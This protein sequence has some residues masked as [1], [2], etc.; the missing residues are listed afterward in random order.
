MR[1][2]LTNDDGVKAPSLWAIHDALQELGE[3]TVVA[4]CSEQ[5][6]VGHAITYRTPITAERVRSESG[7][8]A[9]AV[10]GT[11]AD[12]VK[13]ALLE[14]LSEPPDLVV[15][16]INLGMNLGCNVFYSG[17]VAAAIEGAMYGLPSVAVSTCPSNSERLPAVAAQALRALQVILDRGGPQGIAYNVNVPELRDGDPDILFT[18]HRRGAFQKCYHREEHNGVAGYRL[19]LASGDQE[20]AGDGSDVHAVGEGLISVT[21]LSSSLT[22]MESLRAME[23]T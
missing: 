18:H 21:P 3:V 5:S 15:S 23:R 13:L 22:H 16:G 17:T 4:P 6:G 11:P 12:C 8:H 14:T 10:G 19:L 20:P 1:I 9:H 2:L 7:A